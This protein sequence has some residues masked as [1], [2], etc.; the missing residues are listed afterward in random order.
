MAM[1]TGDGA[2]AWRRWSREDVA[3]WLEALGLAKY[4][5]VF[6]DN[7]IS[8]GALPALPPPPPFLR[9]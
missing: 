1:A 4:Q 3:R 2:H 8:G 6:L 9:V 7:E 5:Q